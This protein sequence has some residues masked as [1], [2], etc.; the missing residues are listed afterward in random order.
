VDVGQIVVVVGFLAEGVVRRAVELALVFTALV[1]SGCQST[2]PSAEA[3]V[4][5]STQHAAEPV[6]AVAAK[7]DFIASG[8]ITVENQIDVTSQ[9]DGIVAQLLADTGTIVRKGQLLARLD[10][11]QLTADRDAAKAQAESIEADLKNW[12]ATVK[13]SQSDL[14]RTEK[15]WAANLITKE[16]LDHDSFKLVANKYELDRE[17]KNYQR[18]LNVVKSLEL[19]LQKTEITAPFDG[20]VARRYIRD[21]QH[22]I[23]GDRLFW[24]SALSPLR[25]KFTLPEK[26]AAQVQRG[27][28]LQVLSAAAP[29]E[30]HA[31][32]VVSISPVVDPASGT[33]DVT[34]ELSGH[35]GA[36]KPGMMANIKLQAAR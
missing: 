25:V 19:E 5:V 15:M 6:S 24:V 29:E 34:A 23:N 2:S 35:P 32:K 21:G 18:Q 16:Q 27:T 28:E 4:P 33:I 31:A 13:V 22:V 3:A 14:D 8:P 17:Q 11:R 30:L 26:L 12:D 7:D 9:R 10:S 1:L 36:L 20:I